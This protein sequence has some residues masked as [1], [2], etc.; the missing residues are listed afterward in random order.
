MSTIIF[1]IGIVSVALGLVGA[2]MSAKRGKRIKNVLAVVVSIVGVTLV[3]M[4]Y[5]ANRESENQAS[6]TVE[7]VDRAEE[8]ITEIR[9]PRRLDPETKRILADRM[10]SYTGQKY[11]MKVFRDQDSLEL[12]KDIHDTLAEAGWVYTN[13][14]PKHATWDYAETSE[15]GLYLIS[16]GRAETSRT[17]EARMALHDVLVETGLYD[18]SSVLIPVSCGEVDGPPEVGTKV[19]KIPCSESPVRITKVHFIVFDEVIPGDTLVLHI[20]KEQL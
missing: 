8:Q 19:K 15:N 4:S 3:V 9:T 12:G 1:I 5:L 13:V 2:L 6:E 14:Y 10:K 18:D 17:S 16:S 20:G 7:R 11:D